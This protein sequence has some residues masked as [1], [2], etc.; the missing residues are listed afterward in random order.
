MHIIFP[1]IERASRPGVA[2]TD[3]ADFLFNKRGN[4]AGQDADAISIFGIKET[5]A[6]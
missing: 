1:H 6:S 5:P 3:A 4:L 2:F